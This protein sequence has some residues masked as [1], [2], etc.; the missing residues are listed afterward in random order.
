M[1]KEFRFLLQSARINLA[2]VAGYAAVLT[3]GAILFPAPLRRLYVARDDDP[4]GA[5]A[6]A[7]LTE[8]ALPAGIEVV[9]L[10]PVLDDFNSDLTAFGR[11]RLASMIAAQLRA[12]DAAQFLV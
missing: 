9:P 6:V 5:G 4:A 2:L 3:L 10:E 8:R 11:S 1:R 7:T 12:D